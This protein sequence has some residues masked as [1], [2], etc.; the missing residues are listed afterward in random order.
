VSQKLEIPG[1]WW[2]PPNV[3]EKWVGTLTL[4]V[5]DSP[6]LNVT[7]PIG[8]G[9]NP[10][11]VGEVLHGCNQH[12]KPITLLYPGRQNLTS[13][14]A[15]SFLTYH[16]GFAIVGIELNSRDDFR[17][18]TLRL[19]VQHFYD[20]VGTSGFST[21][22]GC[23]EAFV[24]EHRLPPIKSF[25]VDDDLSV[26][27]LTE[28]H[29]QNGRKDRTVRENTLLEFKSEKG[30]DFAQWREILN[31]VRG[32]LHFGVLEPIYPI[33]I[34]CEKEGYG[35]KLEDEFRPHE[36]EIHS[37][38]D[39][40]S[41]EPEPPDRWLFRFSDVEDRFGQFL[42]EWV[43]FCQEF[44][45]PLRCYYTTVYHSLPD[46]VNHIC[47]TQALEAFHSTKNRDRGDLFFKERIRELVQSVEPQLKN[48]IPD[49]EAFCTTVRDNRNFYT[50]HDPSLANRALTGQ[51]LFRLNEKLTLLFQMKVLGE[52]GIP[53]ERFSRLRRQLANW[54]VDYR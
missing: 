52:M 36:I 7:V 53:T 25:R 54:I 16:A 32:F 45:E 27:I 1:L 24:I 43:T 35:Q 20:W 40:S 2:V 47:L 50:H 15:L 46:T 31:A 6:N 26:R 21:R 23:A 37:G 49:V 29:A 4:G 11:Q 44:D 39:R 18:N 33:A 5:G 41:V 13:T 14:T 12:G 22:K 8:F 30:F 17:I 51:H 38:L 28:F 48:L 42:S 34:R 9:F 3:Q 10:P 19:D